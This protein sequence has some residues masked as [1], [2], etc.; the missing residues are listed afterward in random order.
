MKLV[1]PK[2]LKNLDLPSELAQHVNIW[3]LMTKKE[4]EISKKLLAQFCAAKRDE[5]EGKKSDFFFSQQ[6]LAKKIGCCRS[7]VQRYLKKY[8]FILNNQHQQAKWC[9]NTYLLDKDFF[10]TLWLMERRGIL[11]NWHKQRRSVMMQLFDD[12]RL[13]IKKWGYYKGV[14]NNEMNHGGVSKTGKMNH[15]PNSSSYK[16][17]KCTGKQPTD[18]RYISQPKNRFEA[19]KALPL[20]GLSFKMRDRFMETWE[21]C[22]AILPKITAEIYN[23]QW[24]DGCIYNPNAFLASHLKAVSKYYAAKLTYRY[25]ERRKVA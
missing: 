7:T 5:L 24:E 2:I 3:D 9:A 6:R 18:Q 21:I 22:P 8:N 16:H 11:S 14:M 25:G 20:N 23:A 4:K 15:H 17:N 19:I 12:P 13:L 1:N 10:E